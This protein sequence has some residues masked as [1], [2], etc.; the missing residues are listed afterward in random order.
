MPDPGLNPVRSGSISRTRARTRSTLSP[1]RPPAS[2][3]R[4]TAKSVGTALAQVACTDAQNAARVLFQTGDFS[5]LETSIDYVTP[6]AELA[7]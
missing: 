7:G 5:A 6:N 2:P 3:S 4:E 1:I